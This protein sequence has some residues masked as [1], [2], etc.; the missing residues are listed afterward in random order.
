MPAARPA[1][2]GARPAVNGSRDRT[3]ERGGAER[4]TVSEA[5]AE[6][7]TADWFHGTAPVHAVQALL[8]GDGRVGT[9]ILRQSTK[10]PMNRLAL[11]FVAEAPRDDVA[12]SIV[13]IHHVSIYRTADVNS[14]GWVLA[15]ETFTSSQAL[16][17]H[18]LGQP[19][20]ISSDGSRIQLRHPLARADRCGAVAAPERDGWQMNSAVSAAAAAAALDA[21]S[22][23]ACDPKSIIFEG[24]LTKQG[25]VR[26]NWKLRWFEL[27]GHSLSYFKNV[28]D[29]QPKGTI[30]LRQATSVSRADFINT[31]GSGFKPFSLK[32]VLTRGDA[33]R[34]YHMYAAN[35]EQIDDWI[36]FI[37]LAMQIKG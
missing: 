16:L 36:A 20:M 15:G 37:Q 9:Y 30:D 24:F 1:V 26:R 13:P 27:R 18:L 6:L 34:G 14:I 19:T 32:L 5:I 21:A 3:I 8:R 17:H 29:A 25:H 12:H 35:E 11:S 2:N 28:G 23:L 22:E 10:S 7:D 31:K 33:V 4:A